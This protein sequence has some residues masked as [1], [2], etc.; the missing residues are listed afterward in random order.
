MVVASRQIRKLV[1]AHANMD[2]E[3]RLL[4]LTRFA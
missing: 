3:R 1:S 4:Q 2:A